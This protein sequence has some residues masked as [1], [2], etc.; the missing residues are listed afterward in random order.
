M[1]SSTILLPY[2]DW[3]ESSSVEEC[4]K[5]STFNPERFTTWE[6]LGYY[7]VSEL[8]PWVDRDV[9][10]GLYGMDTVTFGRSVNDIQLSNQSIVGLITNHVPVGL[11]GLNARVVNSGENTLSNLITN[12]KSF[13]TIPSTSFSYTAG[14][15]N[16]NA[17]TSLI[18]GGYDSSRF[19]PKT[20]IH[21]DLVEYGN[22]GQ[23][24]V[25][26][27]V[28]A[29]YVSGEKSASWRDSTG[30][31]VPTR[32]DSAFPHIWLPQDL[33]EVFE[34]AY[35]LVW[36]D[37]AQLYLVNGTHHAELQRRN[38][39]VTF[40]IQTD[41]SQVVNY[42]LPYSAFDLKVEYPFLGVNESSSYFPLKR[43]TKPSQYLLGRTFLQETYVT[44][45]YDRLTFNLSQVYP[46]GRGSAHIFAISPP[47]NNTS[48]PSDQSESNGIRRWQSALI[49]VCVIVVVVVIGLLL[50]AWRK[51]WF[52]FRRKDQTSVDKAMSQD[53][54]DSWGEAGNKQT[55]E[56]DAAEGCKEV[57]SKDGM[58]WELKGCS[59]MVYEMDADGFKSKPTLS[60]EQIRG[61]NSKP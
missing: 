48:S 3:C 10:I 42:T 53:S 6:E 36:N 38:N 50:V 47:S 13:A 12:L 59:G 5:N 24:F 40:S 17:S 23:Y 21:G 52:A 55:M 54:S 4:K 28:T 16:R 27:D 26:V 35:D 31:P 49:G 22:L 18:L 1:S 34:Q 56:M 11:F 30:F 19:D 8:E 44:V 15:V 57:A 32:I 41:G 25:S 45:D 2:T 58:A 33:C 51:R 37:T 29:V 20:T 60:P 61:G 9:F 14:A 7:T 43:A 46:E 39:I